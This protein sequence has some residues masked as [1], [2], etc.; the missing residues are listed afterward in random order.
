MMISNFIALRSNPKLVRFRNYVLSFYAYD[1]IYPIENL[2]VTKV[3]FAIQ[4]YLSRISACDSVDSGRGSAKNKTAYSYAGWG[5]GDSLDRE[6]VRDI[7]LEQMEAPVCQ[8][9]I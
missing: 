5:D 6:R 2:T 7:I 9:I 3:E 8:H 4:S 1:G